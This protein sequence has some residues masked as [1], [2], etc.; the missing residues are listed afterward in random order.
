MATSHLL[1]L[2]TIKG[3][4]GILEALKHNKRELHG[5]AAN[6]DANRTPLNYCLAGETTPSEIATHAKVQ[7]VR[8]GIDKPR[9]NGVMA[10]EIIFS[11]PLYRHLQD[12]KPF[13]VDCLE[14]L[15]KTFAGELLSFDVHL[16]E[17]APHAHALILPLINKKMQGNELIGGTGNLMR[18][19]NLFHEKVAHR[20]G[21]SRVDY[22]RLSPQD[23]L[24]IEHLVLL[25]LKGDSVIKSIIWPYIRDLIHKDPSPFAQ[26]LGIKKNITRKKIKKTFVQIMTSKGKGSVIET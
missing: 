17:S 20:Y 21:L 22:K 11:L 18:L 15:N 24:N 9:K 19:I 2:G 6:I 3:K 8:A 13:F 5:A 25:R 23:K 12:T 16:D 10:V 1:R 26:L 4:N 7:M 14:W